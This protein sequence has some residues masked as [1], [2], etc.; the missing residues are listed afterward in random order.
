MS[1]PFKDAYA[2]WEFL[3]EDGSRVLLHVVMLEIHGNM[4]VNYVKLKGLKRDA[5]YEDGG[6]GKRYYGCALMEAG[7]PMPMVSG[8]YAACEVELIMVQEADAD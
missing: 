2:A 8:E 3:S 6:T 4:P 5:L 1:N 7:M